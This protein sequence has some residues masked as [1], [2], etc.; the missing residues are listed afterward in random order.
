LPV[1]ALERT[2]WVT[3]GCVPGSQPGCTSAKCGRSLRAISRARRPALHGSSER[4]GVRR[5]SNFY[6][7]MMKLEWPGDMR[8]LA[9]ELALSSI[10]SRS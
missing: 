5:R 9:T 7:G 6:D 3:A 1:R 10:S 8:S 4:A 2:R